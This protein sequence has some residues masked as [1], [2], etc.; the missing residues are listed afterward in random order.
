M[1][2]TRRVRALL[3]GRAPAL[4]VRAL[5]SFG[6][7]LAL[8]GR[9][10]ALALALLVALATGAPS[11]HARGDAGS[12][13]RAAQ[14]PAEAR[15]APRVAWI[16]GVV[17]HVYDGDSFRLRAADGR[18]LG[19]RI[20]GIDAPERTQPFANVARRALR[21]AID[22]REVRVEAIKVDAYQRVVGRVFVGGR[23][24]GLEQLERG[25]A[26]HFTRYDA[27]LAPAERE[28]YALAQAN[29]RARQAGLW[30]Q[31]DPLAPW[32]FRQHRR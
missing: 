14:P 8:S 32:L 23:D 4:V 16:D 31:S 9:A 27:D 30:R 20:A 28:R 29:A 19:I 26:W 21:D 15:P 24:I 22:R 1:R 7:A 25:L 5:P 2:G 3:V 17:E 11:A 18:E 10:L 6:H 12:P 13:P